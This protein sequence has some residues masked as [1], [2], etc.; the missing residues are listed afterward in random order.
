M[1]ISAF[2][3]VIHCAYVCACHLSCHFSA[4]RRDKYRH[5]CGKAVKQAHGGL[6]I[7]QHVEIIAVV[8]DKAPSCKNL[9]LL[10]RLV[11]LTTKVI[12]YLNHKF[13]PVKNCFDKNNILSKHQPLEPLRTQIPM[14]FFGYQVTFLN[15]ISLINCPYI[16][17]A[18]LI[19]F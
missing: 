7:K 2:S 12:Q 1:L 19:F 18:F 8:Q 9:Q 6:F 17:I 3:D 5:P 14:L 15:I 16:S 10:G 13:L 11:L 4:L